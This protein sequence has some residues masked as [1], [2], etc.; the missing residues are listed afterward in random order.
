[1]TKDLW[2]SADMAARKEPE[3]TFADRLKTAMARA[4]KGAEQLERETGIARGLVSRYMR[5]ERKTPR[6]D[7]LGKLCSALGVSPEWLAYG[8]DMPSGAKLTI[9]TGIRPTLD[10]LPGYADVELEVGRLEPDIHVDVFKEARKVSLNK[11]P[12]LTVEFLRGL[13][14]LLAGH[15]GVEDE[16]DA[17]KAR[18]S[19][20][21]QRD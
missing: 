3:E 7:T 1:M 9:P 8:S 18:I 16:T 15:A 20:K 21:K 13:V 10:Q 14:R 12:T 2:D 5:S 11:T 19:K 4:G 6:A 17:I